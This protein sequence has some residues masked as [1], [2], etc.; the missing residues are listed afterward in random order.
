MIRI[1]INGIETLVSDENH[2]LFQELVNR[3]I[4]EEV[5][6]ET[7]DSDFDLESSDSDVEFDVLL[8]VEYKIVDE[9]EINEQAERREDAATLRDKSFIAF[10]D[11]EMEG[12]FADSADAFTKEEIMDAFFDIPRNPNQLEMFESEPE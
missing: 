6:G 12:A 8:N 3:I 4:N 1:K 11:E 2:E 7:G 9:D 5:A 10:T